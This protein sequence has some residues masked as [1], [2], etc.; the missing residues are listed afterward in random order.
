MTEKEK[1]L[2]DLQTA[3]A[4]LQTIAINKRAEVLQKYDAVDSRNSK[5][6][7]QSVI[8]KDGE[9]KQM[10]QQEG[11]T[12]LALAR[13]LQRNFTVTK[14]HLTQLKIHSVGTGAKLVINLED[15]ATASAVD[16]FNGAYA[17]DC[18]SR[19]DTPLGEMHGQIIETVIREGSCIVAFDDFD[20]DD[21]K[22]IFWEADQYANIEKSSWDKEPL[23]KQGYK[24]S[25]GIITNTKGKVYGYAVGSERGRGIYKTG[26]YTI[27]TRDQ[28][29]LLKNPFRFNQKQGI[30]GIL[31]AANQYQDTYEALAGELQTI[32]AHSKMGGKVTKNADYSGSSVEEDLLLKGGTNPEAIIDG[33]NTTPAPA[34]PAENYERLEALAGGFVDYLDVGE[35]F[36]LLSS[37]RPNLN[38]K[39]FV[40][41]I[42]TMNGA[43]LGLFSCYSTGQVSTSYTAFRG[44]QILTWPMLYYWQ[45]WLE[46][47]FCDWHAI[48]AIRYG[49]SKGLLK[50]LP[51]GWENK[52]T[53]LFP[54]M[55]EV[56]PLDAANAKSAMLK[57]GQT[58]FRKLLGPNWKKI[59]EQ[60]AE[61]TSHIKSIGLD[62]LGI[63]ETKAG[64]P[65]G[66]GDNQQAEP[67]RNNDDESD[68]K[69][70]FQKLKRR[71]FK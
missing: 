69:T 13:D 53:F 59:L 64:A 65:T 63:F 5:K 3:K 45:K 25:G 55:P 11:L 43:S 4:K 71:F 70:L 50:A 54:D 30:S 14:A 38:L 44:E 15:E 6:R 21:G 10:T 24:Q 37:N 68:Q 19:D 20:E 67:N 57:N 47:R 26:E 49:I 36:T 61:E 18:D 40:D 17:K 41:W 58:T 9:D 12:A 16:W 31:T 66:Q 42:T 32:K 23:S 35:D 56:N 22:L 33:T 28:A 2:D 48:K 7:R 39:E 8:E 1:A 27:L 29:K 60:L 62:W 46:R 34:A 51:I 52:I